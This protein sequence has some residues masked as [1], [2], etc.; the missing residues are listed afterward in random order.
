MSEP[1]WILVGMMGAGK[2]T[3]GKRIAELTGRPL[4]DTDAMIQQR[5]GRT[6]SQ[7]FQIYGERAFRDHETE[8]LESFPPAGGVL[9]TGGGIVLRDENWTAMR[10]LG[11]TAYLRATETQLLNRLETSKRKR[12][13]LA[14]SDW[15]S[16]VR[17][18]LAARQS[19][20]EM[21]DF[22]LD[23]SD[24][25]DETAERA[26]EH[27]QAWPGRAEGERA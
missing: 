27:F 17:Q 20:Y 5:F 18:I 8:V 12:P 15:Q 26:I 9:S 23:V 13:L 6:V 3:I 1:V 22:V 4:F 7:I 2:T 10:R 24:D 16:K 25:A 19:R 21:A 14:D 11:P